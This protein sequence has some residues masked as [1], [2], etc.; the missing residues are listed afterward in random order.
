M[1]TH[2]DPD[3]DSLL[4]DAVLADENW[5]ALDASLRRDTLAS[6]RTQR[7]RRRLRAGAIGFGTAALALGAAFWWMPRSPRP[8]FPGKEVAFSPTPC[9]V[10]IRNFTEDEL[11]AM[12]PKGSCVFAEVDGK[13]R[14]FILDEALAAKG[15]QVQ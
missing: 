10:I 5:A 13:T 6:L 15:L 2:P 12:F 9:T 8:V 1:K 4:L 7:R 14:F 11:L 3:D